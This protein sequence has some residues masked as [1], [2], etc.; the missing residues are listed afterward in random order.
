MTTS[1]ATVDRGRADRDRAIPLLANVA[2]AGLTG[3][4]GG[5]PTEVPLDERHGLNR[6]CVINCDNLFTVP[7]AA[8]GQRRGRLDPE[9]AA[10]LRDAL[11][12]ALG[13]D[14]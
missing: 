4:V 5:L 13:L 12:I 14:D 6:E 8:L 10:R 11:M 9:S 2:L 3:T 1:S 7:K